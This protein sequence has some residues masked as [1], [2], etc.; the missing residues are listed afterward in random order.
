MNRIKLLVR[1]LGLLGLAL[2]IVLIVR[3]GVGELASSLAAAGFGLLALQG[4]AAL[5]L[6]LERLRPWRSGSARRI[7]QGG[8]V[9][10]EPA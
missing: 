9:P 6:A 8:R 5:L 1:V 3:Q 7:G 2:F 10:E 4:L